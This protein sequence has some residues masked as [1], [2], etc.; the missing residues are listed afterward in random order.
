MLMHKALRAIQH[1]L[2]VAMEDGYYETTWMH[3]ESNTEVFIDTD[4]LNSLVNF[5]N[6]K[7]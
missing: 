2:K 4:S 3:E 7:L 5:I 1:M 6:S